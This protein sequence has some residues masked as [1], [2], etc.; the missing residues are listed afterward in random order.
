MSTD[1]IRK[2]EQVCTELIANQQP[3]TFTHVAARTGLG[4]T[5]LYRNPSLRALI[6]EHRHHAAQAG[7]SAASPPKSQL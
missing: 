4:R 2:I 3:I 1:V 7:T 6:Q 5:T